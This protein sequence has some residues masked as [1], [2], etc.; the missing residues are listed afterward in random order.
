MKYATRTVLIAVGLA[1]LPAQALAGSA[2]VSE[3]RVPEAVVSQDA[4][5]QEIEALKALAS[6]STPEEA[7]EPDAQEE[8]PVPPDAPSTCSVNGAF[9][10]C[11]EVGPAT[12]SAT[13]ALNNRVSPQ[14]GI[15]PPAWCAKSNGKLLAV[16]TKACIAYPISYKTYQIV[17]GQRRLTGEAFGNV[18]S[19]GY[20]D[21]SV[22]TWGQQVEVG[23]YSGWGDAINGSVKGSSTGKGK[24]TKTEASFPKKPLLPLNS[25]RLGESFYRSTATAAGAVG[26]CGTT[27]ML[28]FSS[29]GYD[30]AL[31]PQVDRVFRCDNNTGGR[32]EAGCVVPEYAA[33]LKYKQASYPALASHVSRAQASGLPGAT[34]KKP[35][36]RTTDPTT[37]RDN[38]DLACGDAPSVPDKSCDEYPVATSRQGL[39][40]GGTRRTFDDCSLNFPRQTG[41]SGA[42][43]CMITASENRAQGG[44]NTQFYRANRVLDGDPFRVTTP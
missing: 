21:T 37:I 7:E 42:S 13:E 31:L 28:T 41:R 39:S 19:F 18:Y 1:M 44:L 2:S 43:V 5:F 34:F 35:L 17:N 25:W 23:M 15:K 6:A 38:R 29:P 10:A 11:V 9:E 4:A 30:D 8:A 12:P 36:I 33:E 16:R 27:W 20:S 40:A 26:T 3:D 14:A 22:P 24:C 32:T